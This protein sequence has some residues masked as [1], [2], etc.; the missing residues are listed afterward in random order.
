MTIKNISALPTWLT[1]ITVITLGVLPKE[2]PFRNRPMFLSAWAKNRTDLC[3]FFDIVLWAQLVIFGF[4]TY[5]ITM[6]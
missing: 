4:G 1:V 2:H 3:K 6:G 5:A